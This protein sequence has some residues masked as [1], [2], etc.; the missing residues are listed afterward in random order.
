MKY[1]IGQTVRVIATTEL[2]SNSYNRDN[3]FK[4]GDIFTIDS[5]SK[6]SPTGIYWSNKMLIG[7]YEHH[8]EPYPFSS[9][10]YNKQCHEHDS[11]LCIIK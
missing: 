10:D 11:K 5:Y 8:I 9:I 7:C 3:G 4:V 2:G 1:K 6:G